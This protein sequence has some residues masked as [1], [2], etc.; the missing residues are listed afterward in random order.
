MITDSV[1][2][3][4]SVIADYKILT[5]CWSAQPNGSIFTSKQIGPT[6]I[7]WQYLCCKLSIK[8]TNQRRRTFLCFFLQFLFFR[9]KI[10]LD[11]HFFLQIGFTAKVLVSTSQQAQNICITFVKCR[12][13]AIATGPTLCKCYTNVLCLLWSSYPSGMAMWVQT[14]TIPVYRGF[15]E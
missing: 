15:N 8:I 6:V 2:H 14:A 13:N 4:E 7:S 12:P 9:L 1:S 5:L 3:T 11:N 10:I